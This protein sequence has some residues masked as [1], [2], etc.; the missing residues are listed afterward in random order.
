[1]F[2]QILPLDGL[3]GQLSGTGICI[4]RDS[5]TTKPMLNLDDTDIWPEMTTNPEERTGATD[6]IFCLARTEM[7][8]IIRSTLPSQSPGGVTSNS[9]DLEIRDRH[10]LKLEDEV[11]RKYLRY[12]EFVNPLHQVT[13]AMARAGINGGRLRVRLNRAK[14]KGTEISD[15]ERKDIWTI[16]NKIIDYHISANTN[17]QLQ[18]FWW[19][20]KAFF[21]SEA[22]AWI[23]NEL[24][25]D[26]ERY[27]DE[28]SWRKI[29]ATYAHHHDLAEQ[30]RS[31]HLAVG[32]LTLKA[33]DATQAYLQQTSQPLMEEKPFLERIRARSNRKETSSHGGS[34]S[35][36]TPETM[37][38][39]PFNP[40]DASDDLVY[41]SGG[42][43][44]NA[45]FNFYPLNMSSGLKGS[46]GESYGSTPSAGPGFPGQ[47][48]LN[49][50]IGSFDFDFNQMVDPNTGSIDWM[51]WDQLAQEPNAAPASWY[52]A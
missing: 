12:C 47:G 32:R 17:G 41:G 27:K 45:G 14:T 11:E 37:Q 8:K 20:I 50:V 25:R 1:M 34:S 38:Y 10:L 2:W 28:D 15:A 46:G 16:A 44:A 40:G 21:Q 48:L 24:R 33:W 30:K 18:R 29:E 51:F 3:A 6:M 7:A 42:G 35:G 36:P 22:L 31:L 19:H 5:W 26:P 39:N 13:M 52:P 9:D 23:L 4:T 43:Q 49:P